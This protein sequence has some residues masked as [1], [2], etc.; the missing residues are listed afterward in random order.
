MSGEGFP[1]IDPTSLADVE[2]T[3]NEVLTPPIV[4]NFG[5]QSANQFNEGTR[6]AKP[7]TTM[8]LPGESAEQAHRRIQGAREN[9]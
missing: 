9:N 4:R 1:G 2:R 3:A 8:L 5:D 7:L 6:V